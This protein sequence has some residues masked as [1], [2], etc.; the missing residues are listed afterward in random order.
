L[1]DYFSY[2]KLQIEK[3]QNIKRATGKN[4]LKKVP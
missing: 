4:F 2:K 3:Q 1:T